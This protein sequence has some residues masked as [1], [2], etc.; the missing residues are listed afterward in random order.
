MKKKNYIGSFEEID[1]LF[2]WNDGSEEPDRIH[3]DVMEKLKEIKNRNVTSK[4]VE[5]LQK[6]EILGMQQKQQNESK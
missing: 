6:M 3:N 5:Q 4:L 1:M 2:E